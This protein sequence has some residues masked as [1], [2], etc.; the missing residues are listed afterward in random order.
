M[1]RTPP[2]WLRTAGYWFL[3]F[4]FSVGF[5]TKFWSGPTFFGPAY[6]EKFVEWGFS[7]NMRFV[8]GALELL[9]A[10]LF[11][12]PRRQTRFFAAAMLVFV[13]DAATTVHITNPDPVGAGISA[14][15]HLMIML[16]LVAVNWPA[17]WRDVVPL[18]M[19]RARKSEHAVSRGV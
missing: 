12:I 2:A 3:A 18:P 4:E 5:V 6:S 17:D 8:V 1:A 19:S 13:L 15:L 16:V 9:A 7:P 11:V 14:P 10:V